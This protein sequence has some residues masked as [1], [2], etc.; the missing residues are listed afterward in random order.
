MTLTKAAQEPAVGAPRKPRAR[1]R[2]SNAIGWMFVGP[3]AIVPGVSIPL[4]G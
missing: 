1:E 4:G 3:F 2:R